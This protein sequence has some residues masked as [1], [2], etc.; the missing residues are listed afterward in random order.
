MIDIVTVKGSNE[1]LELFTVDLDNSTL[2]LDPIGPKISKKDAKIKRV[3][4]R[5][6]RDKYRELTFDGQL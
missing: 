2:P 6:A 3:K 5:L 1:P 4:Q